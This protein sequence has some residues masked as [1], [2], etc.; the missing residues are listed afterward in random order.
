MYT[1][2]VGRSGFRLFLRLNGEI[3]IVKTVEGREMVNG[4]SSVLLS[5]KTKVMD[6]TC[7]GPNKTSC[8]H[9]RKS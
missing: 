4:F 5:E 2:T 1:F 6:I 3:L 7:K 9:F 8:R